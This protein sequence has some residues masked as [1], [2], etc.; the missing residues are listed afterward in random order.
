MPPTS[1]S[2]L[3]EEYLTSSESSGADFEPCQIEGIPYLITQEDLNDLVRD[4]NLSKGKSELLGSRL[5]QWNLLSSGTKVSFYDQRSKTKRSSNFFSTDG[6]ICYY[7]DIPAV[8]ESIGINYNPDDWRLFMDVFK[9]SIKAVLLHKENIL[10]SV[11]VAY[12]TTLKETYNILQ[13]I[14][15]IISY[16]KS[17]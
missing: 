2:I 7:N 12:S 9:E 6:E 11:P 15:N 14:L 10:L 16:E 5:Q 4:L 3:D 13:F 1:L 17:R 8:F